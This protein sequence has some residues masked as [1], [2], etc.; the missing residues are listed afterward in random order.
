MPMTRDEHEALLNELINPELEQSRRTEI[1]QSLRVDYGSVITD[2]DKNTQQ[3]DKL[4]K[5][6]A[7]LVV[8]NSKLFRQI[9]LTDNPEQKKQEEQKTFSETITLEQIEGR[10]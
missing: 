6:N 3:L 5:D 4:T 1:L 9:G 8:S 2:F 10:N 7:D